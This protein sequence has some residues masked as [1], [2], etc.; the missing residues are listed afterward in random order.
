MNRRAQT[1]FLDDADATALTDT[2]EIEA[3]PAT[4]SPSPGQGVP[5]V[6][7]TLEAAA[8]AQLPIQPATVAPAA[9]RTGQ[10]A[11]TPGSLRTQAEA[12]TGP[13]AVIRAPDAP[14][15][16]VKPRDVWYPSALLQFVHD[17]VALAEDDAVIR[18]WAAYR[19]E[20]EFRLFNGQ[21]FKLQPVLERAR[22]DLLES[23]V[24]ANTREVTILVSAQIGT[25]DFKAQRFP[26]SLDLS[27][28]AVTLSTRRATVSHGCHLVLCR[29]AAAA[30][31]ITLK[32]DDLNLIFVLP[33]DSG[34][35]QDFVEKRTG[36]GGSVNRSVVIVLTVKLDGVGF[37]SWFNSGAAGTGVLE[38][39]AFF[40]DQQLARPL[41]VLA[42]P[43]L[44]WMR[45]AKAAAKA[46]QMAA[47]AKAEE[48]RQAAKAAQMAAQAKA[49][50]ERQAAKAAQMAASGN[51]LS[52]KSPSGKY[53]IQ[54]LGGSPSS[55]DF[56]SNGTVDS[57]HTWAGKHHV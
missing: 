25:Y 35:A 52:A 26:I 43:D 15:S 20:K 55:L 12:Q 9:P 46:A 18:W 2:R 51:S 23:L 21:E 38:S 29:A 10:L 8:G 39:A 31:G 17:N 3:T 44:D 22:K 24:Q 14:H 5:G 1:G 32:V 53:F 48:E 57:G 37:K 27:Q 16:P 42:E 49:E 36:I 40:P 7:S 19:F 28:G 4:Q 11:P 30:T 13:T 41:Y 6:G 54:N 50:E 47:Q 34:S 56:H 45:A 33:M